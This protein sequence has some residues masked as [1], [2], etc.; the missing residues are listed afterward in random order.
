MEALDYS[1]DVH[2]GDTALAEQELEE[3]GETSR[4]LFGEQPYGDEITIYVQQGEALIRL[5]ASSPE[6]DPTKE[7]IALMEWMLEQA[8]LDQ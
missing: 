5:S 4:V 1:V 8:E 3:L 2:L 6:G 7:A